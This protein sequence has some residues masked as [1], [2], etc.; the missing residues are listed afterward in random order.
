MD[1]QLEYFIIDFSAKFK[2]Q[3][4]APLIHKISRL[5]RKNG[6]KISIFLPKFADKSPYVNHEYPIYYKLLS[7]LFG[8]SFYQSPHIYL[9]LQVPKILGNFKFVSFVKKA[10]RYFLTKKLVNYFKGLSFIVEKKFILIFPTTDT[11]S[12]ELASR[13]IHQKRI[14]NFVFLFRITGVESRGI[15]ASGEELD[16]L[17]DLCN[18]YPNYIRLGVETPGYLELLLNHKANYRNIFWTP[19]YPSNTKAKK[20]V[21]KVSHITIGFLGA[22]KKRKGFDQI[23]EILECLKQGGINF[24]ALIQRAAHPWDTY[25]ATISQLKQNFDDKVKLLPGDLD[26]EKFIEYLSKCDIL[27][28]PYDKTSYKI[29]SSG[30]LYHAAELQIPVIASSGTGFEKEILENR[31]GF[32]FDQFTEV[33]EIITGIRSKKMKKYFDQYNLARINANIDYYLR[34]M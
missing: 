21:K 23:P 20:P 26:F 6:F 14:R 4:N 13:I 27:I 3:H 2:Y 5:I 8:P 32:V 29:N 24:R 10:Y 12:I 25:E 22:A 19:W 16:K 1:K 31:I 17:V 11:L 30:L 33:P 7:P 18:N 15:L 34:K 28:L 9:L